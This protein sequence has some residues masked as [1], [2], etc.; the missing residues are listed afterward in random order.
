MRNDRNEVKMLNGV[1]WNMVSEVERWFK[2][3]MVEKGIEHF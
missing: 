1:I 2:E 3:R